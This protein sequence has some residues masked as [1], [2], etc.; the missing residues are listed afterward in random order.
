ML[1]ELEKYNSLL[2][3]IRGSILPLLLNLTDVLKLAY[4][5]GLVVV[6]FNNSN[7]FL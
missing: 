3:Y 2:K 4:L 7:I 5:F 1:V 6:E